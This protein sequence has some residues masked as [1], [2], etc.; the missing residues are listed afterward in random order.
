M[1]DKQKTILSLTPLPLD[2]DSRT[3]KIATSLARH[4]FASQVIENRA[5]RVTDFPPGVKVISLGSDAVTDVKIATRTWVPGW[6]RER[7]HFLFFAV[8]YLFVRPVQ[9]LLAGPRP[10]LYY[11]H[12]Y[13]LYP[14]VW[15]MR[16][17]RPAPLIYDAHDDY[18]RVQSPD[19]MSRFWQKRFLPFLG[20][21]EKTCVATADA[22]VTVSHGVAGLIGERYS[23]SPHVIRNC[24]DQR[25][26]TDPS[27]TLR[28]KCG[29]GADDFLIAVVGNR[30]GGQ[31][32]DQAIEALRDAPANVHI[33]F[34]GRFYEKV[35]STAHKFGVAERVHAPG[36]AKPLEIVPFIRSA[37]AAA[38]LYYPHTDNNRF[39]LPNG[40]FQS[41]AA[42][43]P[44]LYPDLPD[45]AR[46]IGT[47][48]IGE[49]FD[50]QDVASLADAIKRLAAE[51]KTLAR[52]GQAAAL[53]G[54]ETS[55]EHEEVKL[56]ALVR[57]VLSDA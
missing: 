36:P 1:N 47:N 13:R 11:L 42:S 49:V 3:L 31:A 51:P 10:T 20:W 48:E 8:A 26:D 24:H 22:V 53:L 9:G 44:L 28:Q 32:V 34:V 50:P 7:L 55:W 23:I 35:E 30:K 2:R 6:L 37:D 29:L 25:N 27:E 17:F 45:L 52:R 14:L 16:K 19:E 43:L 18:L 38:L 40:F 12:E 39:I 4:G 46:V 33:A 41:L 56:F 57:E 5:S 15:L 21:M 54:A